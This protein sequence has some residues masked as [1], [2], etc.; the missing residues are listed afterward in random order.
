[1]RGFSAQYVGFFSPT[2]RRPHMVQHKDKAFLR[3]MQNLEALQAVWAKRVMAMHGRQRVTYRQAANRRE[4]LRYLKRFEAYNSEEIRKLGIL[5]LVR[6]H[7]ELA[8]E[9]GKEVRAGAP[10]SRPPPAALSSPL[11]PPPLSPMQQRGARTKF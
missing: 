10:P 6:I 7:S 1:M 3:L 4:L 11:S 9:I 2:V 8:Q 5:L